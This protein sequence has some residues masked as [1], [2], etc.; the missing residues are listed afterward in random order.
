MVLEAQVKT[1]PLA[2]DLRTYMTLRGYNAFIFPLFAF[3]FLP[4]GWLLGSLVMSV[5]GM[6]FLL[7]T[8]FALVFLALDYE[9][10]P[11]QISIDGGYL[12]IPDFSGFPLSLI[13]FSGEGYIFD[14]K[15]EQVYIRVRLSNI[16]E[17]YVVKDPHEKPKPLR[18]FARVRVKTTYSLAL[19]TFKGYTVYTNKYD[20]TRYMP[21]LTKISED[22]YIFEPE[23]HNQLKE[24]IRNHLHRQYAHDQDCVVA[25]MVKNLVF[26]VP[27]N[28]RNRYPKP[29]EYP[30][31]SN[32]TIYFS[33]KDPEK[34]IADLKY[35]I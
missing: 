35:V 14:F 6:L 15:K 27:E 32:E 19:P 26:T 22:R 5:L 25:V 16:R 30:V 34:F 12:N 18:Q 20:Q 3:I 28:I 29:I 9:L 13:G 11:R 33:V 7:F 21:P 24:K 8:P 4:L 31:F 23:I 2:V 1:Y 17:A 10:Y